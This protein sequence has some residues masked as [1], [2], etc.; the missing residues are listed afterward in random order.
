M[1][2][3]NLILFLVILPAC[4]MATEEPK[5]TVTK[6]DGDFEVRRYEPYIVAQTVVDTTDTDEGSNEG[7][8][9]IA[10]YIFGGNKVR[11]KIAMTAPVT[12][13]RSEKI[14]MTA[15]VITAK[16]AAS[17]A[18]SFVMPS[19]YTMETLPVP[20][21]T[22]VTLRQVPSR[23]MAVITFS[24][25]WT[26]ENFQEH[27]EELKQWIARQK[28]KIIGD[29]VIARYNPPFIPFFFRHNEVQIPI[30]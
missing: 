14:A 4:A 7:F 2:Y 28:L 30:E 29:P 20:D 13:E 22:R 5:Y 23:T 18:V 16:Q 15:P 25:R 6:S 17:T 11:Q 12:T 24:G 21:D 26:D 1:T 9:R 8:R 10:G 19:E 3:R 27:T